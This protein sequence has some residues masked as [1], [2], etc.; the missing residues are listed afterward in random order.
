MTVTP[1]QNKESSLIGKMVDT[2]LPLAW[3][4]S[5]AAALAWFL[6]SNYFGQQKLS[7]GQAAVVAE[8][9]ELKVIMRAANLASGT[10]SG[11]VA[12]L[13]FRMENIENAQRVGGKT[14]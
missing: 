1:E 4:L 9:S 5:I 13:K 2:R 8:V 6:I 11:E 10:L 3:L 12:L 14:K 7:D